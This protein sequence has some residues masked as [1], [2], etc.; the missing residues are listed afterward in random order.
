MTKFKQMSRFP[1]NK[2]GYLQQYVLTRARDKSNQ[3]NWETTVQEA[4][5]SWD[6]IQINISPV[7]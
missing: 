3:F 5:S 2:E 4:L 1:L 7:N 6:K